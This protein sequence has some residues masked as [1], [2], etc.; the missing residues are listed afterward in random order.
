MDKIGARFVPFQLRLDKLGCFPNLNKPRV[1]WVGVSG[2][3][4]YL[5]DLNNAVE[6]ML[7]SLGWDSEKRRYHPHLTIGR[8][9][10]K[11]QRYSDLPWGEFIT[12]PTQF[13]VDTIHLIESRLLPS[14]AEYTI[15]HTSKFSG[16]VTQTNAHV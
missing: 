8:V 15:R 3:I 13:T 5:L 12:P 10:D 6:E 1:I 2:E 4:E 9:K 7:H 14:G 16:A 11:R